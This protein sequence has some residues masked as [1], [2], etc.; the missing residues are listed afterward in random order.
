MLERSALERT[1][2]EIFEPQTGT[3]T[4]I[5]TRSNKAITSTLRRPRPTAQP[6]AP[7]TI[8]HNR[9][10]FHQVMHPLA[11]E[12]FIQTLLIY[13]FRTRQAPSQLLIH[14][15]LKKVIRHASIH[16]C[17]NTPHSAHYSQRMKRMIL[18]INS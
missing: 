2:P 14:D 5:S 7:V 10:L 4:A 15:R 11:Q 9:H 16:A 6:L 18:K 13:P 12:P 8:M 17:L 1:V 3:L